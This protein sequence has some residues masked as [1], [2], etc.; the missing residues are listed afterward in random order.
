MS[1]HQSPQLADGYLPERYVVVGAGAVGVTLA[2]EL[3]GAGRQ[4]VLIARGSQLEHARAGTLRYIRPEGEETVDA[5]IAAPIGELVLR[6]GDVLVLATKSQD[7]ERTLADLAGVPARAPLG[8]ARDVPVLTL[9]NGLDS[10]RSA[11]RRFATVLAGVLWLPSSYTRP[12]EVVSPGDPAV[13]TVW[14]GGYRDG[15]GALANR[16]AADLRAASFEAQ[17]VADIARWKAAKLVV[18]AGFGLDALYPPSALRDAARRLIED[19]ARAVLAAAGWG[20]ADFRT[21]STIPL[22]RSAAADIPDHPR[23]GSSTWQ[24]LHTGRSLETDFLNGEIVLQARLNGLDAPANEALQA[25]L[26]R[27]RAEG[28]PAASLDEDDLLQTVQALSLA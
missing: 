18:A 7:S 23:G 21:E 19:E 15:D 27:A 6:S 12:G 22:E 13:G 10:E 5:S 26:A 1:P 11:L 14:L 9:Q 28:T 4:V 20:I 24:S 17:A 25:R 8:S 2:V 16:V 3:H